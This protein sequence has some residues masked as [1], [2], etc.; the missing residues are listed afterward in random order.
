MRTCILQLIIFAS[1]ATN[2]PAESYELTISNK[3]VSVTGET[4]EKFAINDSIPGPTLRFTEGEQAVIKVRNLLNADTSIHWHGLLLPGVMDGVPGMN[5]FDGIKPG[6]TF[7]YSFP[8]RQSGTYWYHAHSLGQ[9]QDGIYGSIIVYPKIIDPIRS[10]RDYVVLLSEHT[11]E[12]S[13]EIFANLK[14]DSA[15]YNYHQRTLLDFFGDIKEKGFF[16]ALRYALTWGEMRMSPTDLADV[17]G[18]TFLINGKTPQENWTGIF[19]KGETI[20]LRFINASAMT[21]YDIRIPGLKMQIVQADGQN[22]K[23]VTVDEFRF[24]AAETYDVL[25]TPLEDKAFTIAA[26]SIDRTGFALATLAPRPGMTGDIPAKRPRTLL[27]MADMGMSHHDESNHQ[28]HQHQHQK[29]NYKSS[30]ESG[31]AQASTPDGHKALNYSDLISLAPQRDTRP[32][33]KEIE[34]ILDGNM[35]RYVWTINNEVFNNAKPIQLKFNER[36]R[37]RFINNSMMAHPMHL[38]GMFFQI[39]N[40]QSPEWRP[41]K[42]TIIIPPGKSYSV[43]LTADETGEWAFHCHLL[44]HMLS[45]MMTSIVVSE[46]SLPESKQL[47]VEG[48]HVH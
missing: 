3:L 13:S 14:R 25:V 27:T 42:H 18:Y 19:N 21:F 34:L 28:H 15:Y 37:L 39:E 9:E 45:G 43:L 16:E 2:A 5:G 35:E 7:T 17:S 48:H 30:G 29:G 38:H 23:P 47:I 44:Y 41:N 4:V 22:V 26:E 36:V 8:L 11:D 10:D 6:E 32:P 1:L 33:T 20:R 31:W 24:G 46:E 12:V 40:G